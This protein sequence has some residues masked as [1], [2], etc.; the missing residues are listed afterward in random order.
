MGGKEE[1]SDGELVGT[2][3]VGGC[4][5]NSDGSVDSEVD[6][7]LEG[8]RDGHE[9]GCEVGWL[10]VVHDGLLVRGNAGAPV[11]TAGGIGGI[12]DAGGESV[13]G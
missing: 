9:V 10:D 7:V 4:V 3:R 6:G 13:G 12:G 5:G 11:S 1:Y 2:G 8:L